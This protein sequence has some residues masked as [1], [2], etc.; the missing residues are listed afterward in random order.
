MRQPIPR[1]KIMTQIETPQLQKLM[2]TPE[3]QNAISSSNPGLVQRRAFRPPRCAVFEQPFTVLEEAP[4][5]RF[6][7]DNEARRQVSRSS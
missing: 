6:E 4:D 2:Q 7:V 3:V 5:Y 1:E